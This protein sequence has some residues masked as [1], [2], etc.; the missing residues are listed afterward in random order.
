V[1]GAL[2]ERA[3]WEKIFVL[4]LEVQRQRSNDAT[5]GQHRDGIWW[6]SIRQRITI[7]PAEKIDEQFAPQLQLILGNRSSRDQTHAARTML[8]HLWLIDQ[9]SR[10]GLSSVLI[11]EADIREAL[12]HHHRRSVQQSLRLAE[13]IATSLNVEPWSVF[14]LGALFSDF[15]RV[16]PA[17]G[18]ASIATGR[19]YCAPQ[20]QCQPWAAH[21]LQGAEG[22]R[23]CTVG[24]GSLA[25]NGSAEQLMHSLSQMGTFCRGRSSEGYAVH[26]SAFPT[27]SRTLRWY[28]R[29]SPPRPQAG[30]HQLP[31]TA[32]GLSKGRI[33]PQQPPLPFVDDWLPA[34][35][36]NTYV[37]P[38]LVT[39]RGN[40]GK[41][42]G[43]QAMESSEAFR[44]RCTT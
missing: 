36:A 1:L 42:R 17:T 3:P 44:R 12:L 10:Q 13:Q 19:K 40:S 41:S 16:A 37:L 27:F 2:L 25:A 35:L 23:I 29:W 21:I 20:C 8:S 38:N 33:A 4:C 22:I 5:C 31:A 43:T 32:S 15:T 11:I 30:R 26:R 28:L 39:Q 14:R 34:T 9:A 24:P 7:F 6:P 18:N